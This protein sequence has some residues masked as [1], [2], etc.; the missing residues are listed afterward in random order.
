MRTQSATRTPSATRSAPRTPSATPV[1]RPGSDLLLPLGTCVRPTDDQDVWQAVF[2]YVYTGAQDLTLPVAGGANWLQSA[3][4]LNQPQP[5]SFRANQMYARA[6]D[7]LFSVDAEVQWMLVVPN[8]TRQ[9]ALLNK[10]SHRCD[11]DLY[12]LE[13]IQP[14]VY[15]CV[16]RVSDV[17]TAHFGY[18]N[19]NPQTIELD[20]GERN[21]FDAAPV[22]RRQPRVF[23]PGFVADAVSVEFDCGAPDWHVTWM[24]TGRSATIGANDLC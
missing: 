9:V 19:P 23:W 3:Y 12:T 7:V 1:P 13:P 16:E 4:T 14:H 11:T 22:D 18:T 2:G 5:T 15:Q 10:Y 21:T 24:V 20:V 6:F 8:R 17:C